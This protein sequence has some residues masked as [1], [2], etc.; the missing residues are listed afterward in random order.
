MQDTSPFTQSQHIQKFL[1]C[2]HL[3]YTLKYTNTKHPNTSPTQKTQLDTQTIKNVKKNTNTRIALFYSK[4]LCRNK[5]TQNLPNVYKT[6]KQKL[7]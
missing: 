5:V 2:N 4:R 3:V 7:I 1:T 6:I